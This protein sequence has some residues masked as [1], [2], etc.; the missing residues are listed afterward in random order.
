MLVAV[1]LIVAIV[2]VVIW[3]V[4]ARQGPRF[5]QTPAAAATTVATGT[6]EVAAGTT[7]DSAPHCETAGGTRA[8]VAVDGPAARVELVNDGSVAATL[9]GAHDG[10]LVVFE[11]DGSPGESSSRVG[12]GES[13]T[14]WVVPDPPEGDARTGTRVQH[15]ALAVSTLGVDT[16][17]TVRL[18]PTVVSGDPQVLCET[19]E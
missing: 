14:A 6:T 9:S 16:V 8:V 13:V 17:Q 11:S 4:A 15:L 5:V 12:P 2:V 10:V 19:E 3:Q 7:P 1:T 18:S